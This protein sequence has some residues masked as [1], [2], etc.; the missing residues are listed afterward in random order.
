MIL[1]SAGRTAGPIDRHSCLIERESSAWR[2]KMLE[3]DVRA[4]Q[5]GNCGDRRVNYPRLKARA[6]NDGSNR[7]ESACWPTAL[8]DLEVVIGHLEFLILDVILPHFIGDVATGCHPVTP[9]PQMLAS[10]V[11]A[12]CRIRREQ[13]MRT[14]PFQ[15]LHRLRYRQ[16]RRDAD[17]HVHVISVD[18]PRVDRHLQTARYFPQ[19]SPSSLSHISLQHRIAVLRNPYQMVFTVPNRV[20]AA[21]IILHPPYATSADLPVA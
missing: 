11:L 17:Q 10:V 2:R 20:A 6:S 18:R 13:P 15:I 8:H 19:Q 16:V 12:Q 9:A 7:L 21:L 14:L 3:P 5:G 1:P 4:G